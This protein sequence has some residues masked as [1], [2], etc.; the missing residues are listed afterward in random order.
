M[1]GLLIS[2]TQPIVVVPH[3]P[4]MPEITPT[5]V[6][7]PIH[8]FDCRMIGETG[9][10]FLLVWQRVGE[11]GYYTG[12]TYGD[13]RL[14]V[15]KTN[16]SYRILSDDSGHFTSMHF[17]RFGSYYQ[18]G[19]IFKDALKNTAVFRSDFDRRSDWGSLSIYFY[20]AGAKSPEVFAGPC[21]VVEIEQTPL[22]SAPEID[23]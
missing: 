11:R 5:S 19:S 9:E 20:Y 15:A 2:M 4:V 10:P 13:G 8:K 7:R 1:I 6:T 14:H 3:L 21:E 12:K 17:D 18:M 23:S 22:E 16:I